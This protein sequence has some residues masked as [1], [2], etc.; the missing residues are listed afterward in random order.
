MGPDFRRFDIDGRIRLH[1][2]FPHQKSE[3]HA[4]CREIPSGGSAGKPL[5]FEVEQK[6]HNRHTVCFVPTGD[7]VF[8]HETN[9]F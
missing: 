4:H 9:K 5:F 1:Y 2:L 8:F 3:K 6:G 7:I